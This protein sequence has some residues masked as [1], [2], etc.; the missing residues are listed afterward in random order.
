VA[1]SDASYFSQ[2]SGTLVYH[3]T[4]SDVTK[5]VILVYRQDDGLYIVIRG[6]FDAADFATVTEFDEIESEYGIFH[7]GFGTAGAWVWAQVEAY[8]RAFDGPIYLTGHSYGGSVVSVLHVIIH[9]RC[10]EESVFSYF[11]AQMPAMDLEI[12]APIK[13]RM[14]T[15]ANDNDIIPTL[16][17]PNCCE[18]LKLLSPLISILPTSWVAWQIRIVLDLMKM[19]TLLEVAFHEWLYDATPT[20]IEC[21]KDY[22]RGEK[23]F[24]RHVA[25]TVFMI[26]SST[27]SRLEDMVVDPAVHL[28][29]LN[30]ALEAISDHA[31]DLYVQAID[32][33]IW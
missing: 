1:Y 27:P 29:C 16:S 3:T 12:A 30:L 33:L 14:F 17:I 6:S 15:F 13:G 28:N 10:P 7:G 26:D 25:G 8:V 22:E 19:T 5:P 9:A 31:I 20:I 32:N 21:V 11:Y 24:V 23:A 2:F 4:D 18:R